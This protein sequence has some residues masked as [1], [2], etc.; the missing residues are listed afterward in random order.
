MDTLANPG[1]EVHS[2]QVEVITEALPDEHGWIDNARRTD[3]GWRTIT[4][5]IKPAR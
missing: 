1:I 3:T 5:I 2:V 4:I